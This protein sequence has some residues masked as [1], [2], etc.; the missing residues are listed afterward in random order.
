MNKLLSTLFLVLSLQAPQVFAGDTP[1]V[2][3]NESERQRFNSL[4]EELRCLVCQNQSL[5]DSNAD[6]AEDLRLEVY[7]MFNE[8]RPNQEIIEYLVA[9]YGEFVLY[10]PRLGPGTLLLWFGP[11]LFLLIGVV[12]AVSVQRK[13]ANQDV[14]ESQLKYAEEL[15]SKED[16]KNS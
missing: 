3:D 8:G 16:D 15:L 1:L 10:R 4:L 14:D 6:L 2:F 11:V 7:D 9:R 5:A 12:I 13:S